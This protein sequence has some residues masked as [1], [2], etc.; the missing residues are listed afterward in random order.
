M[1]KKGWTEDFGNSCSKMFLN[2]GNK[3]H[4]KSAIAHE[5]I[6]M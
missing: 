4:I 5:D 6:K 3:N 1:A 2:N